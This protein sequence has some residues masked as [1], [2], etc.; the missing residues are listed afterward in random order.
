MKVGKILI[1]M[2][3]AA[4]G[5]Q[6]N[7]QRATF[8]HESYNYVRKYIHP[9]QL[10][11]RQVEDWSR[12]NRAT[13]ITINDI[14]RDRYLSDRAKSRKIEAVLNR[15]DRRLRNILSRRQYAKFRTLRSSYRN[16]NYDRGVRNRGYRNGS[17]C[18]AGYD[19]RRGQRGDYYTSS[20]DGDY[21]DGGTYYSGNRTRNY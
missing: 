2:I 7:A 8:V 1:V 17:S 5:F 9:L 13:D 18:E 3:L 12:L 20:R 11:H 10:S 21:Y 15:Q 16:N 6:M 14:Q 19:N 4:L